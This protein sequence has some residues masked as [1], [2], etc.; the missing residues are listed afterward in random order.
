MF[1]LTAP[2]PYIVK[3]LLFC[4]CGAPRCV[5]FDWRP[6]SP[7]VSCVC[8]RAPCWTCTSSQCL[9]ARPNLSSTFWTKAPPCCVTSPTLSSRSCCSRR[10]RRQCSAALRIPCR[11]RCP[12]V[13][14]FLFPCSPACCSG[15]SHTVA[16]ISHLTSCVL[17]AVQADAWS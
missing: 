1:V 12:H 13:P 5:T 16:L 2:F 4:N 9:W 7:C 15:S 3:L 11:V 14:Q 8:C 6:P 17:S 10:C